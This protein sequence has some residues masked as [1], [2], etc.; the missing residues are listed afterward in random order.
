[1]STAC[2]GRKN[3]RKV[4][5]RV[6]N[7]GKRRSREVRVGSDDDGCIWEPFLKLKIAG[8][9]YEFW[10][11]IGLIFSHVEE[12]NGIV[13]S[14]VVKR[15][16]DGI[17]VD[18]IENLGLLLHSLIVASKISK[19]KMEAETLSP[20]HPPSFLCQSLPAVVP[21]LLI[22]T[23]YVDPG[24]WVATVEDG[25]RFGFDLMA[26]MLIFNFAAIFCQYISARIGAITGKS[27]AQIC[28]D[29]YDTWTCMLLGVQTE[30][31]IFTGFN[32]IFGWDLFTCVFL[33]AT[34]VVFHILL[35]VFLDIE[36]AKILGQFVAGFVFLSFILGLLINQ[37]EVP[38]SMN[39]I[40]GEGAFVLMSLPGAN[41]VP[42]NF[43]LHSS[44]VQW[45]QGL[46]SIFKNALCHNHFLTILC[47]SSGLYFVLR[48]PI[49]LLGFLL[50]L[51][52]ANQTTTLT[53]SLGREVVVHGFLKLDIP[54]W[55][56]FATIR[57]IAVLP[58]LYCVRSSGAEGMYQLLLSTQVLVALQ[59]PSFVV[60]LFRVATSRSIMGVHKI[61]Q[62]LEL[63][64]LMIF[65][66]MLGL[67][68]FVV[69]EMIFGNSDW[70][71]DLGWNVGSGVSVSFS[72]SYCFFYIVM[73]DAATPLRSASV[74]LDAQTWNWD[75]PETLPNPPV[76][77]EESYLTETMCHEDVSKHVEEHTPVVA[78]SWD[79]SDVITSKFSS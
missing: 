7:E 58:V 70:A 25:A 15:F 13:N 22:S 21:M 26:V 27:L 38:F 14:G 62:F 18:L 39:G 54:G 6:A 44:I 49:A 3:R 60:P 59:L 73:F 76:V 78:K 12:I 42:H 47:V 28:S 24:K 61:S 40:P 35:S 63:L 66:G 55:L 33:A 10:P 67:N 20:N 48:S 51:F 68:I 36:K 56:H 65:V 75:M 74:Q 45:H 17:R 53:L 19:S 34:S 29:E 69:V 57:V 8:A 37:P 4:E 79:Y 11:Q 77:G 43:Y 41:L 32:L 72:S 31:S 1:M 71:S 16:C 9:V 23:V 5:K 52:L 64:A 46:T 30:L 2:R 50:I